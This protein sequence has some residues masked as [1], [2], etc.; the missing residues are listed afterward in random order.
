MVWQDRGLGISKQTRS[1]LNMKQSIMVGK[2]VNIVIEGYKKIDIFIILRWLDSNTL[3]L[4]LLIFS[5]KLI[6]YHIGN[7]IRSRPMMKPFR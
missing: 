5:T 6:I 2:K 4:C 1:A 3:I 7:K